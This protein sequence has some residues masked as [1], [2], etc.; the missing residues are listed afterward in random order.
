[1][2]IIIILVIAFVVFEVGSNEYMLWKLRAQKKEGLLPDCKQ[3]KL[4]RDSIARLFTGPRFGVA[5]YKAELL[6]DEKLNM[7]NQYIIAQKYDEAWAL[8]DEMIA[9]CRKWQFAV[10]AG[11][12]AFAVILMVVLKFV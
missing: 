12:L 11:A 8:V 7:L 1:M 9:V 3:V 6:S 10:T 2:S 5:R 4:A